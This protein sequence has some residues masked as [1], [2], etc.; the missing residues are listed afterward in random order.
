MKSLKKVT[1]INMSKDSIPGPSSHYG[2]SIEQVEDQTE[3]LG[4][5]EEEDEEEYAEAE[6]VLTYSR[7][8]NDVN[9]ILTN[10]SVSCIKAGHK[11]IVLGTHFGRIHI[12]DHDGNKF[13][14]RENV[15]PCCLKLDLRN[16][17]LIVISSIEIV[18][19]K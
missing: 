1:P 18:D 2:F 13:M 12:M 4:E 6:P 10:D 11:I 17:A 19:K 5:E 7:M 3:E 9:D 15:R 16:M 14:T 8:K